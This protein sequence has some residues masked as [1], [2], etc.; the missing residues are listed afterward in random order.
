MP[1]RRLPTSLLRPLTR[2]MW[3][4]PPVPVMA[5]LLLRLP[6]LPHTW[7]RTPMMLR[8]PR[9]EGDASGSP[10]LT[11]AE[12]RTLTAKSSFPTPPRSDIVAFLDNPDPAMRTDPTLFGCPSAATAGMMAVWPGAPE[13]SPLPRPTVN[14]PPPASALRPRI[15]EAGYSGARFS[16]PRSFAYLRSVTYALPYCQDIL[17]LSLET[18]LRQFALRASFCFLFPVLSGTCVPAPLRGWH[19]HSASFRPVGLVA[20]PHILLHLLCGRLR[21]RAFMAHVR[22]RDGLS[23]RASLS[24]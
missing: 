4:L 19:L 6:P 17:D 21:L 13:L 16:L 23:W 2:W 14:E 7:T 1:P 18:G 12:E 9:A 10:Y 20:S 11:A 24:A 15:C 8:W 5:R 3:V 22:C